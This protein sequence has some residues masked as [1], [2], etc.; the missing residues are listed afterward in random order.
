MEDNVKRWHI[1]ALA[2]A[3]LALIPLSGAGAETRASLGLGVH[4]WKT[5][6]KIDLQDVEENG[7]SWIASLQMG[8]SLVK[9]QTDIE[10][11][12]KQFGGTEEPVY[13][14]CALLLIGPS[15]YGGIGIGTY[16]YKGEFAEEPFYVLRAGVDLRLLPSISLDI[17]ANYR[18]EDW[19]SLGDAVE[20]IDTDTITLGAGVRLAF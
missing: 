6:D 3:T 12:P 16:Y 8:S 15:I 5:L 2:V 17:N 18:W 14:P 9:F 10:M 11:F 20:E 13:A 1:V 4:Y 7:L 19:K